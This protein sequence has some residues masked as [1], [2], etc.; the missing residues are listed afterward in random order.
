LNRNL[1]VAVARCLRVEVSGEFQRH[2]SEKFRGLAGS[3]AGGRWSPPGTYP[4]IYLGRP[5]DSVVVEAYRN[6]VEK[7]EG[8]R[9]EFVAPRRLLTCSVSVRDVLDLRVGSN[10]ELVGL[11]DNDLSGEWEPCQAV[12]RAAHQLGLH[13]ILAPAATNLGETLAIFE[14]HL[15]V[16]ELPILIKEERWPQLPADPRTLR[17]LRR[18]E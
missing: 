18:S 8:M 6:L 9:A 3:T 1:A 14:R 15:E 12:G 11:S 13:G 10:M 2:V 7:V 16:E 4:V 5:T 17:L